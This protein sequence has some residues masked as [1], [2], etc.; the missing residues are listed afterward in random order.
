MLASEL[1]HCFRSSF[2]SV[3]S[4]VRMLSPISEWNSWEISKRPPATS[5]S[6]Q[7]IFLLFRFSR[8]NIQTIGYLA[9]F[10]STCPESG[11]RGGFSALRPAKQPLD[12]I[13]QLRSASWAHPTSPSL[14]DSY[15]SS[16]FAPA[17]ASSSTTPWFPSSSTGKWRLS[18]PAAC[19]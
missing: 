17:F 7:L 12:R 19:A 18:S 13:T 6:G 16:I 11:L 10:S 5:D 8:L 15:H 14:P 2:T 3:S 9:I 4:M 1:T